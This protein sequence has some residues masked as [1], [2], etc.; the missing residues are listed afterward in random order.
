MR[1]AILYSGVMIEG[2]RAACEAEL[3]DILHLSNR[4]FYP[5]GRIEMGSVLPTLF[6]A[7]NAHNLRVVVDDGKPVA[8]AGM[9]VNDLRM[10][11]IDV[12]AACF[13]SVCTLESH[14][15]RG[16][17]AALMDDG[18]AHA[19]SQGASLA[20][21]SGKRGLYLRMRCIDA[22]LFRVAEVDG[23]TRVRGRYEV[24]QWEE[25]DIPALQ[26]LQSREAVRFIRGPGEMAALLRARAM[27]CRPARTWVVLEAGRIMAYLCV[28]GPDDRTG[29]GIVLS[30]ELAGSREAVL[31]AAASVLKEEGAERLDVE[32]PASDG[33]VALAAARGMALRAVGRHGTLKVI[34][35]GA[36]VRAIAPRLERWRHPLPDSLEDLA[37]LVFGSAERQ[38]A[39][40]DAGQLNAPFPIPLPGYGLNY[41]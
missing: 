30:R 36:F 19:V 6:A 4:V 22:G 39:G 16:L 34:D 1:P 17:A 23:R 24:R 10:E 21:I 12:R 7:S 33:L 37:A 2:P 32:V 20:L 11:E 9:T 25:P 27:F 28:S 3:P 5:D 29:S 14:R 40:T 15:G 35:R 31:D 8:M 41:I 13:G 18:V 26:A 38:T